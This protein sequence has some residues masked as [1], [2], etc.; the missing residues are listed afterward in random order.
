[1]DYIFFH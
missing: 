1:V